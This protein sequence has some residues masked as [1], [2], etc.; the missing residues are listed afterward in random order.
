MSEL[1]EERVREI[2]REV[3]LGEQNKV[4]TEVLPEPAD[5]GLEEISLTESLADAIHGIAASWVDEIMD[6]LPSGKADDI[7]AA[8]QHYR[9]ITM[10][11]NEGED[12]SWEQGAR[13]LEEAFATIFTSGTS[14][15]RAICF[16]LSGFLPSPVRSRDDVYGYVQPDEGDPNSQPSHR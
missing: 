1:T 2:A 16:R 4:Q 6:N 13:A 3:Y 5:W 11:N 9:Q 15:L 10:R 12:L 7:W 14:E 8:Y